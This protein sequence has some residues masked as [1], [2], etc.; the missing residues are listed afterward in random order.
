MQGMRVA[1]LGSG[2]MGSAA[3]FRLKAVGFD[4]SLWNRS[5]ERGERVAKELGLNFYANLAEAVGRAEVALAFLADDEALLQVVS[6]LPRADGLVLANYS[7]VTPRSSAAAAKVLEGKGIC[8]LETPVLGGPRVLREGKAITIVSGPQRC[9]R[10]A[11]AAVDVLSSEVI[12]VSEEIGK[13]A[14]LKL[15]YNNLLISFV[16]ALA[17]SMTLSES[18]GVD[19]KLLKELLLRTAFRELAER[20]YD[21]MTE[22]APTGF[23]LAL[24]AK[25]MEYFCHASSEKGVASPVAASVAQILKLASKAGLAER[26]YTAVYKFLKSVGVRG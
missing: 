4:V 26:D 20:Y 19:Q 8:Y 17:E 12:Y 16:A 1:V 11:R 9:L 3:A 24:A 6:A 10:L 15:A 13:A 21:R 5:V 25:D 2:L 23:R 18:Y 7:T 14:A 22:D